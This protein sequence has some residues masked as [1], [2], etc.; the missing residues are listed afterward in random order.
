MR[1][2]RNSSFSFCRNLFWLE[3]WVLDV[4]L[5]LVGFVGV[6]WKNYVFSV[7]LLD[8]CIFNKDIYL[9]MDSF[10]Y[11]FVIDAQ[12]RMKQVNIC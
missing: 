1:F 12:K 7:Y 11:L 4:F 6:G 8:I 9:Q 3:C 2:L 10:K 5:V